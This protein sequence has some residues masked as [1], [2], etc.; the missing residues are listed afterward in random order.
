M[1]RKNLTLVTLALLALLAL[2][3]GYAPRQL[4]KELAQTQPTKEQ[5]P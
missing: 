5:R 2:V 1:A 4:A 3:Q